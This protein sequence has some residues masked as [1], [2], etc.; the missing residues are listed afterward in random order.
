MTLTTT[1][2]LA[3]PLTDQ[4]VSPGV[5]GS[6]VVLVLTVATVLLLR[7]LNRQLKK[8]RFPEP[9]PGEGDDRPRRDRRGRGAGP[10]R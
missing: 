5:V 7:S 8:V 10:Q 1:A 2:L 6:L 3:G 4:T 9:P